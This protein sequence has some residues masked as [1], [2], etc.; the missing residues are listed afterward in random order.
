MLRTVQNLQDVPSPFLL[1]GRSLPLKKRYS[2]FFIGES[3]VDSRFGVYL[4]AL[5]MPR[6]TINTNFLFPSNLNTMRWS[7]VADQSGSVLPKSTVKEYEAAKVRRYQYRKSQNFH[8][9]S[10]VHN[11]SFRLIP[12]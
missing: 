12:S 11:S 7:V 2:T 3:T 1:Y 4:A 6:W 10:W 5:E 8:T 9:N